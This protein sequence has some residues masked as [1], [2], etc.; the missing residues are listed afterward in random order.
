MFDIADR[1]HVVDALYGA[2][3]ASFGVDSF[4]VQLPP[5]LVVSE[6]FIALFSGFPVLILPVLPLVI[7]SRAHAQRLVWFSFP[8]QPADAFGRFVLDRVA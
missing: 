7:A 5:F 6:P 4:F 2:P 3:A 1:F 8:A